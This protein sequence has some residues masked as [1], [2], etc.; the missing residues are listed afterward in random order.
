MA[1]TSVQ[2][3]DEQHKRNGWTAATLGAYND[4]IEQNINARHFGGNYAD[5]EIDRMMKARAVAN[6]VKCENVAGYNPLN[7]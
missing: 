7:W 2:D 4:A 5:P 1:E 6:K 3:I